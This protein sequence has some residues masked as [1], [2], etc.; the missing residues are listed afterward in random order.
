[1]RDFFFRQFSNPDLLHF[2][3]QTAEVVDRCL[4]DK[5]FSKA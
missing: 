5:N 1:M 2:A 3:D 4:K